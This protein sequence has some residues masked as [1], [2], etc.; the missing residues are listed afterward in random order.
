MSVGTAQSPGNAAPYG[1]NDTAHHM[2]EA[3]AIRHA[4]NIVQQSGTSFGSGMKILPKDRRNAMYAVY[5]YCREIDDIADEGGTKDEKL[6]ALNDW[7]EEID[8]LYAGQPTRKTSLA[9][10]QPIKRYDLAKSEFLLLLEGMEMDAKG[11]IVRPSLD[12]LMAYCRRVA[13]AVGMLS[14]PIFGAPPGEASER[15]AI[16]LA[17]ALQV[18]NILRDV[19]EDAV[20]GRIYLPAELLIA[21]GITTDNPLDVVAH[22]A[23]GKVCAELSI[24]A[25]ENFQSARDSLQKL[26]WRTVRPAL[27]MMGVYQEYLQRLESRGW[28]KVMEPLK[29][30][31]FEKLAIAVRWA[32]APPVL[33]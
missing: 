32:V 12:T 22:P 26:D 28:D 29:L 18:T 33:S 14:M 30:S 5:A 31:S 3:D 2:V 17:N 6:A 4:R 13:G 8:N 23:L 19:Q 16:S 9:L 24:V 20:M 15:F 27:L 10:L 11:P 7:R 21:H 1:S 25:K